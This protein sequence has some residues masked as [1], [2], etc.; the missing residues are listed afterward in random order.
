MILKLEGFFPLTHRQRNITQ[1]HHMF[2]LEIFPLLGLTQWVKTG[3]ITKLKEK[4]KRLGIGRKETKL[5]LQ[6]LRGKK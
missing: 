2:L 4:K 3:F 6:I 1:S 5:L